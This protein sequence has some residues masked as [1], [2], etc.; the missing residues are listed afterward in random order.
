MP[1]V[2]LQNIP[3]SFVKDA[4]QVPLRKGGALQIFLRLDFLGYNDS[5]AEFDRCH[6]L[7]SQA[8]FGRLILSQIQLGTDKYDGDARRVVVNLGVP[9]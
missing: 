6:F 5:L 9:L 1:V 8:L 2:Y 7:L 3:N 4:L